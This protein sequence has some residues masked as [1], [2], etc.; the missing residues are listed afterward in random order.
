MVKQKDG[1]SEP[2]FLEKNKFN[3]VLENTIFNLYGKKLKAEFKESENLIRDEIE[4]VDIKEI[5]KQNQLS[6]NQN[7]SKK[8]EKNEEKINKEQNNKEQKDTDDIKEVKSTGPLIYGRNAKI[9]K[10]K[11]IKI[12]F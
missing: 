2:S 6:S 1:S 11:I 9:D 5:I 12:I 10:T 7:N 4:K 8:E 3:S